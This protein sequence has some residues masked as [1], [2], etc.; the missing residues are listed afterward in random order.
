VPASTGVSTA[1][2]NARL[3]LAEAMAGVADDFPEVEVR[4]QLVRGPVGDVLRH[5]ARGADLLVVGRHSNTG[6]PGYALG[7]TARALLQEAPCPL[8]LA[9]AT[10][11]PRSGRLSA[12]L[13]T[14]VPVGAG[15]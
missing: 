7:R 2:Q 14:S 13:H 8:M 4:R 10:E 15:Y 1:R 11:S 9:A 12:V 6:L 5:A 3:L